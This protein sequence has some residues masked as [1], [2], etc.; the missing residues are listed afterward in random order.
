MP[1]LSESLFPFMRGYFMTFT[2]FT[3]RQDDHLLFE[4]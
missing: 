2:L 4:L 3:A 1:V